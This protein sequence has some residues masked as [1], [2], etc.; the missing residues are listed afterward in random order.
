MWV[1]VDR[2]KRVDIFVFFLS[3]QKIVD[4]DDDDYA[5]YILYVVL[6]VLTSV[7]RITKN[8]GVCKFKSSS[9]W[10]SEIFVHRKAI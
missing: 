6:S 9:F 1:I 10:L 5:L 7:L 8:P 3:L 4:D 2:K